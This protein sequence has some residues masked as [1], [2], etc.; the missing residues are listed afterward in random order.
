VGGDSSADLADLVHA[1]DAE[2]SPNLLPMPCDPM[3]TKPGDAATIRDY[4]GRGD[5]LNEAIGDFSSA[6]AKQ[7]ERYYA[8]LEAALRKGKITA[9][10]EA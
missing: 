2:R 3:R 7:A 4:V 9:Y 8:A 6:Y 1:S 5:Q 10:L